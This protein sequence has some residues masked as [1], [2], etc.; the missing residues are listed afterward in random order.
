M[1]DREKVV[2]RIHE[3]IDYGVCV[4]LLM[5]VL[6]LL[7]EHE[8]EIQ[9]LR[10]ENHDILTQFHKWAK[11]QPRIVRC[12]DCKYYSGFTCENMKNEQM[13]GMIVADD[14]FCADGERKTD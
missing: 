11:E 4:D 13:I 9:N 3:A 2:E 12:E 1:T 8:A 14:W 5:D 7:K 6:E 10:R